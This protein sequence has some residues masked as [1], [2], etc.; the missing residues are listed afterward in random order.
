VVYFL[1]DFK[2]AY[3]WK[4]AY[5]EAQHAFVFILRLLSLS[6][7]AI[8][9]S[10]PFSQTPSI[11]VPPATDQISYPFRYNYRFAY[12]YLHGTIQWEN[13]SQNTISMAKLQLFKYEI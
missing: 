13:A 8:F 10:A 1:L 3:I 11:Y 12:F 2:T 9:T 7:V 4:S 5:Y 6:Q